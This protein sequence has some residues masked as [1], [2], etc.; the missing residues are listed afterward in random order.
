MDSIFGPHELRFG[1]NELQYCP[2]G[3]YFS[4]HIK[5]WL[6]FDSKN[7]NTKSEQQRFRLQVLF[8]IRSGE[9]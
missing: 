8:Y 7:L 5:N 1:P 4:L 9:N 3:L 2:N 6:C